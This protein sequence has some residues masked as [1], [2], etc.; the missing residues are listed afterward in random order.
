MELT[1]EQ[2]EN[3][4][5]TIG[6][7]LWRL[8]NLYHIRDKSG[9]I[10]K[11][12][13]NDAQL[14]F[15]TQRK[16]RNIWLKARQRGITTCAV[17][18]RLDDCVFIPN[19]EAGI[20]A[21]SLDDA[22]KIF[23]K[24]K[25]AFEMLPEWIKGP[26]RPNTDKAGE[27]SFPNGS[28]FS[29]DTSFRSGTLSALHVSELAK[30]AKKS[31]E[32]A[33]E[34]RT[35]AFEAVPIDGEIDVES[36]AEGM[37][38]EFYELCDEA[39]PKDHDKITPL[40]FAFHFEPWFTSEEYKYEGE[41]EISQELIEYFDYLDKEQGI[42]L[43]QA[44]KNWYALK[45]SSLKGD[46]H[47][48]YPSYPE[49]AFL[50]SGRPVFNNQQIAADIKCAKEV[51][52]DFVPIVVKDMEEQEHIFQLKVFKRADEKFS[53][54][55]AGDPAEGLETG[56]NSALTV[57]SSDFDQVASFA[58]KV[59]PD[60]FAGLLVEVA[61]YF[62]NALLSWET[63]NHGHAVEMGIKRRK[64]YKLFRRK[65]KEK[66]GEEILEQIGWQN[67]VKSKMVMLDKLKECYRDGS[68]DINDE[69]TLREMLK[70]VLEEDGNIYIN[71]LDRVACLGIALVALPQASID[72]STSV[73]VPV[74][75]KAPS[76]VT[77]MSI[78]QKLNHYKRKRS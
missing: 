4:R 31:P 53:Y 40:E 43:T 9:Q 42:K 72:N 76:D 32:K 70:C 65:T 59:D 44:Q 66:I 51:S 50:A 55:V 19:F 46:M 73:V 3:L 17:L 21:H 7:K 69:E 62:N 39:M 54:V 25:L 8:N 30:I 12:K 61:K 11:F 24:A 68:L 71:G 63:N 75:Q 48:E 35:G 5:N 1:E 78:Q 38:G 64:Y 13:L 58:G 77:K 2:K 18:N 27:Y 37:A 28:R 20:I 6:N 10:V 41:V 23:R 29:V 15:I 67:N 26:M 74:G 16:K 60:L 47:Q 57:L 52:F 34:I 56:D 36:T 45:K 49:E 22:E 14:K 33:R